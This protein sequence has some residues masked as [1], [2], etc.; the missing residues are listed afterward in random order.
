MGLYK[1][2]WTQC[3][4]EMKKVIFLNI[5]FYNLL[6]LN[7]TGT[8]NESNSNWRNLWLIIM[9][10]TILIVGLGR[11]FVFIKLSTETTGHL[12]F[13]KMRAFHVSSAVRAVIELLPT[14][15]TLKLIH[16]GKDRSV[17]HLF[18]QISK[19]IY[20]HSGRENS[21]VMFW[22]IILTTRTEWLTGQGRITRFTTSWVRE[23]IGS[24][25]LS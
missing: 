1:L 23:M 24:G 7:R 10:E 16:G 20:K 6:L 2:S 9:F 8:I 21:W 11:T 18:H 19:Y 3:I 17:K 4:L 25:E 5:L 13:L 14:R 22:K 15:S 12:F